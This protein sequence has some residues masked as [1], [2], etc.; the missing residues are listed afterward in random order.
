M[1]QAKWSKVFSPGLEF[2]SLLTPQISV[3]FRLFWV[4]VVGNNG[5]GLLRNFETSWCRLKMAKFD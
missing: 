1:H 4:L 5:E 2:K 3:C